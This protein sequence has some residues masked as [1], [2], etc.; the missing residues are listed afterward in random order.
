[1]EA[2]HGL[3][4]TTTRAGREA[5]NINHEAPVIPPGSLSHHE[6]LGKDW[7]IQEPHTRGYVRFSWG[8]YWECDSAQRPNTS[9]GLSPRTSSVAMCVSHVLG[10][11]GGERGRQGASLP[12]GPIHLFLCSELSGA[13][14]RGWRPG[15]SA[16]LTAYTGRAILVDHEVPLS[17]AVT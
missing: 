11:R 15:L 14:R 7:N 3:V 12:A 17:L 16:G 13:G 6:S 1:M 5:A 2:F 9:V 10:A 8:Q 4:G